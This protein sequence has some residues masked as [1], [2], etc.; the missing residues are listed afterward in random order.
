[1]CKDI[2][3]KH[4]QPASI[5][6][7]FILI[8]KSA[9]EIALLATHYFKNRTRELF[10]TQSEA[11]ITVLGVKGYEFLHPFPCGATVLNS[12]PKLDK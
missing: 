1:M 6:L 5:F 3:A 2:T 4:R 12:L 8:K 10:F 9:L 7:N 11:S